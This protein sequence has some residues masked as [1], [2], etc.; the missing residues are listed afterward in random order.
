[1]LSFDAFESIQPESNWM[2]PTE[3]GQISFKLQPVQV[4]L[5]SLQNPAGEFSL[6]LDSLLQEQFSD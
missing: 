2:K 1:M 3:N 5:V 6:R 4:F